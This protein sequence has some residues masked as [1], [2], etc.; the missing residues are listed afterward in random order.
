MQNLKNNGLI[1]LFTSKDETQTKTKLKLRIGKGLER[2]FGVAT[3]PR[4]SC[5]K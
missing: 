2:S 4:F 3:Y 5:A 1:V